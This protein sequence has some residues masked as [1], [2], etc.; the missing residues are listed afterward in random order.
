MK[1]LDKVGGFCFVSFAKAFAFF[2]VKKTVH[3]P[4]SMVNSA[5]TSRGSIMN[6]I[7]TKE[8]SHYPLERFLAVLGMTNINCHPD[9]G[10]ICRGVKPLPPKGG[11]S[12]LC[13]DSVPFAVKSIPQST[14][15]GVL[16]IVNSQ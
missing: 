4:Q 7:P 5:P 15:D 11:F 13:E 9:E 6:V 12:D 8:G 3:S 1:I 14:V 16:S 10:G 2:A